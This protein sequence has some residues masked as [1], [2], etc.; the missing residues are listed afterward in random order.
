ME[1]HKHIEDLLEKYFEATTTVAEEAELRAYFSQDDIAPHLE[2]YRGMF[3]YFS[4]AKQERY[5]KQGPFNT[6]RKMNFRWLSVAASVVL[7]FGLYFGNRYW[8]QRQAEI[9]YQETK[10][11]LNLLAENFNRGVD[12]IA[13][14]NEFEVAKQKIYNND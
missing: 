6:K 4:A 10:K 14:L 2:T 1:L 11:A 9:A 12:K 5:T 8:E 13:Y 3:H 7:V